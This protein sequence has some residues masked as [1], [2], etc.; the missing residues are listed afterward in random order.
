MGKMLHF[1]PCISCSSLQHNL[2]RKSIKESD[3]PLNAC[4]SVETANHFLLTA[5]DIT[6]MEHPHTKYSMPTYGQKSFACHLTFCQNKIKL[7]S[8]L[9]V[10]KKYNTSDFH[11]AAQ[12]QNS[13]CHFQSFILQ[14]KKK[15]KNISSADKLVQEDKRLSKIKL[16]I[17]VITLSLFPLLHA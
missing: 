8:K 16:E 12:P 10:I 7:A 13:L 11:L 9:F 6:H 17:L 15:R 14:Y 3:S 1:R 4:G 2:H 5:I